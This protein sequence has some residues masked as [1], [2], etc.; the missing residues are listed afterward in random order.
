[1]TTPAGPRRGSKPSAVLDDFI[2]S[3]IVRRTTDVSPHT[4]RIWRQTKQKLVENFGANR[5]MDEITRGDA[6]DWRLTLIAAGL[7][8]ATVRKH[9]GFAKHFFAQALDHEIISVNPFAKLVSSPVGNQDRQYFVSRDETAKVLEAAPDAQWRLIIALSRYGGL[10]CP[11]EHL[12]LTWGDVDWALG[13]IHVSS[14]KTAR[15]SCSKVNCSW[16][17]NNER[18]V[19]LSSFNSYL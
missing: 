1:M 9:C 18:L 17:R 4:Q 2:E 19:E 3:Y 5:P 7:A 11:S 16:R 10:R 12:G 14:P 13:R 15:Q 8:D 6:T